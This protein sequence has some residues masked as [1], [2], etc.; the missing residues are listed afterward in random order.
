MSEQAGWDRGFEGV[1]KRQA[2]LGLTLTP[3]QRLAWL[4]QMIQFFLKARQARKAMP[5]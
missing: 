4:H 5:R 1:Q 3:A 2:V